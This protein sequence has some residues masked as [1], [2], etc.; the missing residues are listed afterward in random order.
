M[1]HHLIV[2]PG[3]ELVRRDNM[4]IVFESHLLTSLKAKCRDVTLFL[5][6]FKLDR[7]VLLRILP[8][9]VQHLHAFG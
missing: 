8:E 4:A 7:Q 6:Q 2:G 5:K 3:Y 9:V 1:A